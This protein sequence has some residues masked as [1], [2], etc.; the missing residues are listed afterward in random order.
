MSSGLIKKKK[1]FFFFKL[2]IWFLIGSVTIEINPTFY[3]F[4]LPYFILCVSVCVGDRR[5][6]ARSAGIGGRPS[7]PWA[8]SEEF[9]WWALTSST[10]STCPAS[11]CTVGPAHPSITGSTQSGTC[12]LSPP[13]EGFVL[14]ADFVHTNV[15]IYLFIYFNQKIFWSLVTK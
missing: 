12:W 8:S 15:A 1:N 3:F 13:I 4:P 10:S 2:V 5:S 6:S 14:L 7:R 11:H 9:T